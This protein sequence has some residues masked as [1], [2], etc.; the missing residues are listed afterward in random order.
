MSIIFT[1]DLQLFCNKKYDHYRHKHLHPLS[2]RINNIAGNIPYLKTD[3]LFILWE[4]Y[5]FSSHD[6]P[7]AVVTQSDCLLS[8][9]SL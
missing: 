4:L 2:R 5:S 3:T 6:L 1:L 7:A 8:Q 9:A